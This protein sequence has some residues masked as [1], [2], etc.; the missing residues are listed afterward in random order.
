VCVTLIGQADMQIGALLFFCF[1]FDE[2]HHSADSIA[3]PV[4]QEPTVQ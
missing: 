1:F 3:P 4:S 2:A